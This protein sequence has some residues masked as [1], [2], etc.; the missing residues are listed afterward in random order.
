MRSGRGSEHLLGLNSCRFP[1]PKKDREVPKKTWQA[2]FWSNHSFSC[3]GVLWKW[4]GHESSEYGWEDWTYSLPKDDIF[5]EKMWFLTCLW[6]TGVGSI[7]RKSSFRFVSR[8]NDLYLHIFDTL[9]CPVSESVMSPVHTHV[10][11][12]WFNDSFFGERKSSLYFIS[13]DQLSDS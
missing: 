4:C 13:L 2:Y 5:E 8:R 9:K 10:S 7:G 12:P 3:R 1:F 11:T 6:L